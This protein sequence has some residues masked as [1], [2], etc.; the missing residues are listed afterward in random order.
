MLSL[1]RIFYHQSLGGL[2]ILLYLCTMIMTLTTF[3]AIVGLIGLVA[4]IGTAIYFHHQEITLKE[5]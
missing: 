3:F 4:F 1:N 5:N 2:G